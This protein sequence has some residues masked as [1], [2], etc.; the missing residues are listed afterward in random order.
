M[1]IY[2]LS[3]FLLSSILLLKELFNFR[4]KICCGTIFRGLNGEVLLDQRFLKPCNARLANCKLRR[5]ECKTESDISDTSSS[6]VY[7]SDS[8]SD[9]GYD[10]SSNPGN[11][12]DSTATS[13]AYKKAE[14][15]PSSIEAETSS[16]ISEIHNEIPKAN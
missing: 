14:T 1:I 13:S 4:E 2:F 3:F 7:N 15:V 9:S 16:S 8:S 12:A 5:S 6:K 10:E 11:V